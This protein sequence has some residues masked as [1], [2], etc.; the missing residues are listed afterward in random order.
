MTHA[1]GPSGEAFAR[2][3]DGLRL[4]AAALALGTDRRNEP[5]ALSAACDAAR[6]F[7]SVL[8]LAA[9]R[10]LPDPQ[11][12]IERLRQQCAALLTLDQSPASA[13]PNALQAAQLARDQ[14]ARVL[15]EL[16]RES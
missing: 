16:A 3:E 9:Q 5:A 6:C 13:M 7:L 2:F 12:R 8:E 14:A 4:L 10:H 15:P 11:G 1:T